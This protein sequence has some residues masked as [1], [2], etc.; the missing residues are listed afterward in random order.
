MFARPELLLL[1]A[2]LPA[3]WWRRFKRSGNAVPFSDLS[4][5]VRVSRTRRWV[6]ELPAGLRSLAVAGCVVAAAG[7]Q[8]EVVSVEASPEGIDIVLVMDV[9]SSMLAEDF[10]PSNRLDVAKEQAITFARGRP[11][12]RIGLVSFAGQAITR[13]PLTLDHAVVERAVRELKVGELE[14]GTA[15]GMGLATAVNR[16]RLARGVSKVAVLLTDGE[17]NRG[18]VDPRTAAQLA[19]RFG[20]RVYTIGVG[21]QGQAPVPI[22]RDPVRYETMPVRLDETLLRDMASVT[23]GRYFRATDRAA[24]R[25]IFQQIDLLEKTPG[26]ASRYLRVEEEYRPFLIVAL[27]ALLLELICSATIAVRVP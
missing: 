27:S 1:L 22:S 6:A 24:L 17:N 18:M 23:G 3:I 2:A 14:D 7:P 10:A 26:E 16:L 21:T 11:H 20:V 19:A 12:D 8:R 9:S 15:I 13:V 5:M 4:G 25:Q